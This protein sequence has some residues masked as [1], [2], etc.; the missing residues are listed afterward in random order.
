M[1]NL[2]GKVKSRLGH[3]GFWRT[4]HYLGY[5]LND[6]YRFRRLGIDTAMRASRV[7]VPRHHAGLPATTTKPISRRRRIMPSVG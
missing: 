2:A 6:A 5:C 1:A 3:Y 7:F 4:V